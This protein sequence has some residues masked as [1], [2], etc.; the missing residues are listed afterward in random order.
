MWR[1]SFAILDP[2]A[3]NRGIAPPNPGTDV[4][5]MR[6]A[7]GDSEYTPY[8]PPQPGYGQYQ[9][10]SDD[11]L[12]NF[13][14]LAGGSVPRAVAMAYRQIGASWASTGATIRTDDLTYSARD[15]VGNW[16]TLADYW[17]KVA[18][19]QDERAADDT[20]NLVSINRVE[21]NFRDADLFIE[22]SP[23]RRDVSW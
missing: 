1:G 9:I 20:F 7:L 10:F 19:K 13:L 11:E 16:L 3:E 6:L 14:E 5:R 4:G 2:M 22:G 17:D 21:R 12:S 8:D 23:S 18:D 15:S